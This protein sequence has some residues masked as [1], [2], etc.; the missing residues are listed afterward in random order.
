MSNLLIYMNNLFTT[1]GNIMKKSM[2]TMKE[3]SEDFIKY[4][5]N[6]WTEFTVHEK[7]YNYELNNYLTMKENLIK[8]K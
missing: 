3:L 1:I 6:E 4:T 7:K 5:H 2:L 8:K